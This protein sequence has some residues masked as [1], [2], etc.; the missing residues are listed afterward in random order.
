M[1][2][3]R[4]LWKDCFVNVPSYPCPECS[5]GRLSIERETL[6]VIE[7]G[8]SLELH[9]HEAW[10][11][12][13]IRKS[14][15]ALLRCNNPACGEIVSVG[16]KVSV[17]QDY[18]DPEERDYYDLFY[19]A[20]FYP[21]LPIFRV[22]NNCP[23]SVASELELSFSHFWTDTGASANRLRT[24][25]EALLT[26]RRIPRTTV[27]KQKKRI[28]LTLHSRIEKFAQ[29][30]KEAAEMLMAIKWIGNSGSHDSWA[31]DRDSLLNG[32]E[33]FEH[34]LEL[35]YERRADRLKRTAADI[36]KRKGKPAT[37]RKAKLF[38]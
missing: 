30:N 31:M 37:K 29:S 26:D 6:S 8:P 18:S 1:P 4:R 20:Y 22:P 7:T 15:S 9:E 28:A 11:P 16:G 23:A 2:I 3:N 32:F 12:D 34:V 14:F 25:T 19:P 27:N 35:L 33:L 13:W 17:E 24:A 5:D 10:D 36:T 21:A 38:R